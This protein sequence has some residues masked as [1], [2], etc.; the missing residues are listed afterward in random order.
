MLRGILLFLYKVSCY[1]CAVTISL[2]HCKI[3]I[4]Y[5]AAVVVDNA[6]DDNVDDDD[7]DGDD[8]NDANYGDDDDNCDDVDDDDGGGV[9]GGD[10]DYSDLDHDGQ[11]DTSRP[12]LTS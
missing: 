11:R 10:D 5:V 7:D 2:F 6:D 1:L 3:W 4:K 8:D 9:G 12:T